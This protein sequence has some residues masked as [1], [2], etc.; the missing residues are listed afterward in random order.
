MFAVAGADHQQNVILQPGPGTGPLLHCKSLPQVQDVWPD[1]AQRR[2]EDNATDELP[3]VW[4]AQPNVCN[5]PKHKVATGVFARHRCGDLDTAVSNPQM[6]ASVMPA[7]EHRILGWFIDDGLTGLVDHHVS[8]VEFV[9]ERRHD[10]GFC[11]GSGGLRPYDASRNGAQTTSRIRPL[12]IVGFPMSEGTQDQPHLEVRETGC[13]KY[14]R[15]RHICA[16]SAKVCGLLPR[17]RP[18]G[19]PTDRQA[20]CGPSGP[21]AGAHGARPAD[22]RPGRSHPLLP[23]AMHL[24]GRQDRALPFP[25]SAPCLTFLPSAAQGLCQ[26]EMLQG[27]PV[28]AWLRLRCRHSPPDGSSVRAKR[29]DQARAFWSLES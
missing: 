23:P 15:E 5:W 2:I 9:D 16:G 22:D 7:I 18:R 12:V 14:P 17:D 8:L 6:N 3:A 29:R 25:L 27:D 28:F 11:G 1:M 26:R 20:A 13:L 24:S 21:C 10:V 4:M 19:Q